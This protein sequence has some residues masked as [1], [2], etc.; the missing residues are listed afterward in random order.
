MK[1]KTKENNPKKHQQDSKIIQL[2]DLTELTDQEA[3]LVVGAW[4]SGG[5][6]GSGGSGG[7]VDLT[8]Q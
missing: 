4:T 3:E 7:T 1:A 6:G 8:G 5:G 2:S